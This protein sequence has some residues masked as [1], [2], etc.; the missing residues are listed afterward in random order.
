MRKPNSLIQSSSPYLLQH[1]Y[2]PVQWYEWGEAA[3]KKARDENKLI[4]VSIGYSACHWC[5]V[6]ERESFENETVAQVMNENFV[7]IKVD[8][9]ERPDIDQVYMLAIQLMNGNGGWPLNVICLPDQRP[10]YGGTYFAASDWIS[11][12]SQLY[13]LWEFEPAKAQHFASQLASGLKHADFIE[14]I[15]NLSNSF[16]PSELDAITQNWIND[17]DLEYGGYK[18]APKFPLPN[19]WLFFLRYGHLSQNE[20]IL[21]M[22]KHS[23]EMMAKGGIYDQ[24]G[25]GFARYSVDEQWHIPHFE[26]MIYDNAQMLSLFAEAYTAFGYETFAQIVRETCNWL[27]REM[28]AENGLFFSAIDA[29]SEGVEGKFY[30]WTKKEIDMVLEEDI[31][32]LNDYFDV[33]PVGNWP[34]ERTNVLRRRYD[35]HLLMKR[36]GLDETTFNQKIAKAKSKLLLARSKRP[37]PALDDKSLTAWNAMVAKGLIDAALALDE[38]KYYQRAKK[39]VT[40]LLQNLITPDGRLKRNY[41]NEKVQIDAFLDDYAF[42]IDALLALYQYDFNEAWLNEATELCDTVLAHFSAS[43]SPFLY[44]TADF[45]E[46][47]ILRKIETMDDVIP[48]SNSVMAQNLHVLGLLTDNDVFIQKAKAMLGLVLP[49]MRNYGS[50]YSNWCL[51]LLNEVYGLNEIAILGSNAAA[52]RKEFAQHYLPNKLFLGGQKSTL[53]L[54]QGKASDTSLIYICKNKSCSLPVA[55]VQEALLLIR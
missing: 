2:N 51:Q 10:I 5:H 23:L 46:Q 36:Y 21:K 14:P 26:K 50:G 13:Q 6:M 9:E 11:V 24:L 1:A 17:F 54:A 52:I 35:D 40:F 8:R 32:L 28:T 38:E 33:K 3:L 47:L 30:S 19:N 41:K 55:A 39:A 20:H 53:P 15:S 48:A 43:D 34:E 45:A 44:Y 16:Q 31:E 27:D 25:G 12:L 18:R 7:C 49:R 22:V 42:L 37:A 29:D 4:I